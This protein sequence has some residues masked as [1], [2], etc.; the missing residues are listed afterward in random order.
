MDRLIPA[1]FCMPVCCNLQSNLL[2]RR[3]KTH[4]SEAI[5]G[6]SLSSRPPTIL[7]TSVVNRARNFV[8]KLWPSSS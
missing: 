7:V 5:N 8:R 6:E 1:S 2:C 3:S 4:Q